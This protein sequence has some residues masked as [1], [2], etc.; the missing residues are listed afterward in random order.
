MNNTIENGSNHHI[1]IGVFIAMSMNSED[2]N[3][4]ASFH[5]RQ[6]G[7][8]TYFHFARLIISNLLTFLLHVG[9][10]L[11]TL[12]LRHLQCNKRRNKADADSRWSFK[13]VFKYLWILIPQSLISPFNI[14]T[15]VLKSQKNEFI[16]LIREPKIKLDKTHFYFYFTDMVA[17]LKIYFHLQMN[18]LMNIM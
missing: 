18:F 13:M 7:N 1:F 9:F 4:F 17:M 14:Q 8:Y 10:R 16:N 3:T 5:I 12:V 6:V 2:K 15:T 11:C